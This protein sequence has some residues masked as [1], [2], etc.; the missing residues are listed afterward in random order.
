[1][2]MRGLTILKNRAVTVQNAVAKIWP[3]MGYE[4]KTQVHLRNLAGI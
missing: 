2:T 3:L 1:M 4:V